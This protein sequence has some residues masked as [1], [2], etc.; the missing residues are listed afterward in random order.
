MIQLQLY[1]FGRLYFQFISYYFKLN[2]NSWWDPSFYFIP[3]NQW[4]KKEFDDG[5]EKK[6]LGFKVVLSYCCVYKLFQIVFDIVQVFI[7]FEASNTTMKRERLMH[8]KKMMKI[9]I[10]M[11]RI[12]RFIYLF[13]TG[14]KG[15]Q[16]YASEYT[17]NWF[18][19]VFVIKCDIPEFK[20]FIDFS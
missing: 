7:L 1:D 12:K 11:K 15:G 17:K 13:K 20:L 4:L 14:W 16:R 2:W 19:Y 10:C 5:Y 3:S 18:Q 9:F 6:K 8:T